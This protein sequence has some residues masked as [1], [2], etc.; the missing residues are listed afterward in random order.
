MRLF[1]PCIEGTV[2]TITIF[3]T[4]VTTFDN[5]TVI[6]PNSKLSNEVIVNLSREGRRRMDIEVTFPYDLPFAQLKSVIESAL[7]ANRDI[8]KEPVT[9]VGIISMDEKGYKV[10]INAWSKAHGY[11]DTRQQV[12]EVIMEAIANAGIKMTA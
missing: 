8:L 10:S 6:F 4:I 1:V 2:T 11:Q 5:R 3:Y 7:H 12:Y 9:R